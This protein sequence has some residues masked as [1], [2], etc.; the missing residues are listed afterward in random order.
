MHG[1]NIKL[2]QEQFSNI[3]TNKCKHLPNITD[4]SSKNNQAFYFIFQEYLKTVYLDLNFI[5]HYP[6]L[7]YMLHHLGGLIKNNG[8]AS[9]VACGTYE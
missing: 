5:L 3:Q 9:R 8:T 2:P 7:F 6:I 1:T 4:K